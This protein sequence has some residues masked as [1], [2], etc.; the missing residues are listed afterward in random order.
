MV[1]CIV[2][3]FLFLLIICVCGKLVVYCV[4]VVFGLNGLFDMRFDSNCVSVRK[5]VGCLIMVVV[6][7]LL[8][9]LMSCML[10]GLCMMCGVGILC[11]FVIWFLLLCNVVL[12]LG[13]NMIIVWWFDCVIRL[14][15]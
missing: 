6:L 8:V 7:W 2:I 9:K 4:S 1:V 14:V 10:I 15:R 3:V 11:R 13:M 5:L 12:C